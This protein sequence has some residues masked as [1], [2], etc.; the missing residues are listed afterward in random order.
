LGFVPLTISGVYSATKAAMHSFSLSLRY[1]L[2]DTPVKVVEL[3]PPWV[4]T[5]L[6]NSSNEPAAMPLAPFID[7]TMQLL[8][9]DVDEVMVERAK[10]MRNN[11]GPG[12]RLM[13]VAFNDHM[14][15]RPE[16]GS[17]PAT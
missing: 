11:A 1:K 5:D 7:E 17:A 6:L 14:T 9:T 3:I 15:G 2:Q 4:Q 16:T 8:A 13:I 10:P 12:E